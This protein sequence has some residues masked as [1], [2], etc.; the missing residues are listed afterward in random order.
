MV[1]TLGKAES[2]PA[3]HWPGRKAHAAGF[4]KLFGIVLGWALS[5]VL[6]LRSTSRAKCVEEY[7]FLFVLNALIS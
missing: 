6:G 5:F 2:K 7:F 3:T 1:P 4:S